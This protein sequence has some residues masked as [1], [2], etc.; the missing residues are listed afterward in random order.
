MNKLLVALIAFFGINSFAQ[1]GC[2]EGIRAAY[3][4]KNNKITKVNAKIA[5]CGSAQAGSYASVEYP[6]GIIFIAQYPGLDVNINHEDLN[7]L[8]IIDVKVPKKLE[9]NQYRCVTNK[10][11]KLKEETYCFKV[12]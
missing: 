9:K 6:N 4:I 1:A 10:K 3:Q 8:P 5:E 2:W 7:G 11:L 12:L